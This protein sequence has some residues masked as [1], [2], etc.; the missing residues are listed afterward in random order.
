[1]SENHPNPDPLA[2]YAPQ[3]RF[4][5]WG[6]AGQQHLCAARVTLIGTGALGGILADTL[7]R[8]GVGHL[9]LIDRDFVE[10]DN[11]HRQ[12]LFTEADAD[13][14][15]PKATAAAAHLARVNS[16]VTLE[17]IVA[18]FA[19]RTAADL[20]R[21]S[22]LLL[23]GTDNL[24]TRYL[25]N[26]VAVQQNTPWVYGACVA[27]EGRVMAILP[28]QTPCLRCVWPTPPDPGQTPTC[29]TVGVLAPAVHVVA[30]LQA[31][32]ALKLLTGN[33]A[34]LTRKFIT[35]DLWNG[36]VTYKDWQAAYE[37]GTCPCCGHGDYTYLG[38][39]ATSL[40]TTL[41]GRAAV[42][43][44]PPTPAHVDLAHVAASL[45]QEMILARNPHLL[46]FAT[47]DL[48]ITLFRDGRAIVQ[49]TTDPATA[50]TAY[51]RYIG[52]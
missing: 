12:V 23:D 47:A 28:R 8:A 3:M 26:D 20:C 18:D 35:I 30:G 40:T 32:E 16:D 27:A 5:R 17:P 1:M 37:P 29:D 36:R 24:E 41:C 42:Q 44:S 9:R 48:R 7:V 52:M 50:R 51:S 22:D 2:R 31:G 45:P 33:A 11:L 34:A 49:G 46:R 39:G 4:A 15:T 13:A 10:R 21:D 43:L 14:A 25:I 38:G 19:P 6:R